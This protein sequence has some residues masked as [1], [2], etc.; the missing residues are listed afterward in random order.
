MIF[1]QHLDNL[2]SHISI[3][4]ILKVQHTRS[5]KS[6]QPAERK[7]MTAEK[8]ITACE[9]LLNMKRAFPH[10]QA[11]YR[12][13]RTARPEKTESS[14]N[15]EES[16]VESPSDLDGLG[17]IRNRAYALP[18]PQAL[19]SIAYAKSTMNNMYFTSLDS[20]A[21]YTRRPARQVTC[22]EGSASRDESHQLSYSPLTS[23]S[24]EEMNPPAPLKSG[25]NSRAERLGDQS[26]MVLVERAPQPLPSIRKIPLRRPPPQ[27][28]R[29][30]S[31]APV[32]F[33]PVLIPAALD[34]I[35]ARS[36]HVPV[37][38][39]L[40]RYILVRARNYEKMSNAV[41]QQALQLI[42][43]PSNVRTKP[44][45]LQYLK[46]YFLAVRD[47]SHVIYVEKYKLVPAAL[48]YD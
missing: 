16:Q 1:T 46:S 37:F 9:A 35:N 2:L 4:D 7:T 17:N 21:G 26:H 10:K 3:I 29:P 25:N 5:A 39:D 42:Q 13:D 38:R 44:K 27:H 15:I 8:R 45:A 12:T 34:P 43:A 30:M 23:D 19:P 31:Q 41:L 18:L 40:N 11:K 33:R 24:S 14:S 28:H 32:L 48:V 36:S 20:G 22:F 6:T 47:R